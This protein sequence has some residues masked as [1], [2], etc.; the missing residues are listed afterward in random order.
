MPHT[1]FDPRCLYAGWAAIAAAA[2]L[3][4]AWLPELASWHGRQVDVLFRIIFWL[5]MTMLVVVDGL[6]VYFLVRYRQRPGR[7]GRPAS[8]PFS[9]RACG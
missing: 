8:R 2:P 1:I 3:R 7:R 4:S 5:T 9:W 6:L